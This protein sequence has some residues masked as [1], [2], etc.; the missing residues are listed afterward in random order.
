METRLIQCKKHWLIQSRT[1]KNVQFW[2]P[3]KLSKSESFDKPS[4][5][6]QITLLARASPLPTSIK[7]PSQVRQAVMEPPLF[8]S[9]LFIWTC[10]STF[11]EG[12]STR[13]QTLIESPCISPQSELSPIQH[14]RDCRRQMR[15]P[16][17]LD[18]LIWPLTCHFFDPKKMIQKDV[19]L[20]TS[21]H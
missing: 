11:W 16:P 7:A 9:G 15:E 2:T 20:L 4:L 21:W 3:G 18:H 10:S 6:T 12:S 19:T 14:L 8:G 13:S 17:P 5:T 1:G